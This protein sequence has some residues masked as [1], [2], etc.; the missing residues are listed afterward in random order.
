MAK[1]IQ[2]YVN[3]FLIGNPNDRP[4]LLASSSFNGNTMVYGKDPNFGATD[5]FYIGMKNLIL[6][7]TELSA[8]TP[9]TLLDW[10][11]SQATQITNVKFD[12]PDSSQHTGMAMPEGGSGTMIGNLLFQGGLYGINMNNQQYLI[13][14]TTFDGCNVGIYISHV[15]DLVVQNATFEN[16]GTGID[17][18]PCSPP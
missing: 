13:K 8:S 14:D 12:M 11:V 2:L 3:T 4:Q 6:V 5:N 1:P 10:S 16:C 15:F 7:S 9:F 18:K 17:G